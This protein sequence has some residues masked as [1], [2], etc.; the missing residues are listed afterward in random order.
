MAYSTNWSIENDN[1]IKQNSSGPPL[2]EYAEANLEI[3]RDV[4]SGRNLYKDEQDD[5]SGAKMVANISSAY[6]PAFCQASKNDESSPYKNGYDLG[7]F[8][9]GDEKRQ[10]G[11]RELVDDALP[12]GHRPPCDFYYGAVELTGSGIRFYGDVCLV[13]RRKALEPS[14]LVLDRNSFDLISEP[15]R[16]RIRAA[17]IGEKPARKLEAKRLAG[18][19]KADVGDMAAV[20]AF[21]TIGFKPRRFTSGQVAEAIRH[22]EDYLE[23]IKY[24]SFSTDDIEEARFS[25]T[26]AAYDALTAER[27]AKGPAPR[28]EA[29]LWRHRRRIAEEQLRESNVPVRVVTTSGRSRD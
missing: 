8:G 24:K 9:L 6:V 7:W 19:W 10:K 1:L 17:Q 15:L 28:L 5:E 16:T 4:V 27:D 29:L 23:V 20:K 18:T 13:L 26:D 2:R 14:T 3:C 12:L 25:A 21:Q 22:D 11:P